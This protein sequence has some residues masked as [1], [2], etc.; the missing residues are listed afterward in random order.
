MIPLRIVWQ[1]MLNSE[2]QTC[3]RCGQTYGNLQRAIAKL[4]DVLTPLGLKPT[5]ETKEVGEE[6]FR[7]D[8]SLSN[9]I[10]I[11]DRPI[12]EWLDATVGG[13]R[14]CSVCGES[15][16]RTVEVGGTVFEAIPEKLILKAALIAAAHM[17]APTPE[18]LSSQSEHETG[19]TQCCGGQ[20]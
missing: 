1:R 8:P 2:G 3:D 15:E 10:W 19:K 14:C 20:C 18:A 17:L 6:S 11:A 9:R 12:E 16:C 13:S 5:L 4:K 7:A